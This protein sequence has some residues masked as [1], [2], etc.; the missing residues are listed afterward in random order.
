MQIILIGIG[1]FLGAISRFLLSRFVNSA[2]T[3]FP[4]GTLAVNVI[5]SFL[6]AL[7]LYGLSFE[8]QI[9][10]NLRDLLAIGFMGS[11]TTMSAFSYETMRFIELGQVFPAAIN[12]VLNVVLCLLAVFLGRELALII[13]R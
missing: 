1:G 13:S 5:G 10:I 9:S 7:I 11:F 2:V 3:S 4:Y 8:K 12:V 6:L